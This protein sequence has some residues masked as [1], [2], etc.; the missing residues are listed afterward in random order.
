V[1]VARKGNCVFSKCIGMAQKGSSVYG[2]AFPLI[3]TAVSGAN[4]T[5]I[6]GRL[7]NAA[8]IGYGLYLFGMEAT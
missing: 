6:I 7:G 5:R 2:R 3:L 4:T 8:W 1:T